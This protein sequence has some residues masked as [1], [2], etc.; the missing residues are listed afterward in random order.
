MKYLT[1]LLFVLVLFVGASAQSN[2]PLRVKEIDGDPSVNLVREIRVTNGTLTRVS[3]GVVQLTV[4]GGS[5]SPGGLDTQMQFNDGAAFGGDAGL[6]YNKTTNFLTVTGGGITLST[7]T[8]NK[9]TLTPPATGATLTVAD[10]KTLTVSNTLTFT[11]TDSAS[12]AFGAGGT[13]AYSNAANTFTVAQTVSLSG[14]TTGTDG[15]AITLT[16]NANALG[17]LAG[18]NSTVQGTGATNDDLYSALEFGSSYAGSGT[19]SI[20][21]GA[22]G[23][24]SITGTSVAAETSALVGS[25]AN[26]GSGTNTL[27]IG[28]KSD[29]TKASTG[30]ITTAVGVKS[31]ILNQNATGSIG[32]ARGLDLSGWSNSGTITTSAGI[33]ADTSIDVGTTKYFIKSLSVSPSELAGALLVSGV[34]TAGTSPTTLTDAA[35][36]ILSA[37]LNTVQ[38]AQGGTGVTA[39]GTGVATALGVNVGSAG[40]F[41]T[42]N[43]ALGTPSSGVVSTGVTLGDVTMNVTGTDATGDIYYRDA[44]GILTRLPVGST[45][46]V[47][48]VAAGLPSWGTDATGGG[49][50]PVVDTTSVVEGSADGTKEV[51]IEADGI[52]TGTVRVWTAPDSNTTIPIFSQIITFAG[53]TAARTVTF[54]DEAFTVAGVASTQTLSNKTLTAPRIADLGFI[55]DA[56]GNEAIIVDTVASAVNEITVANAATGTGPTISAT[57]GDTNIDLNLV[58]KGTGGVKITGTGTSYVGIGDTDNSHYL[59]LQV[60]TNL[61]ADRILTLTTGD[62]ART[63]TVNGNPTLDDWF[64]QSVKVAANPQFATVEV[65]AA[66]DTTLARSSAGNLSVEGN[67]IYRAGGTDVPVADG[68]TGASTLTGILQGN[69]TSAVTA[70]APGTGVVTA[71]GVNVG[72]AGAFVTFNGALGTPSSGVVS[73]GVTLGDVTMNVTG[74]DATG[75]IYY[76]DAGGLLARLGIGSTGQVIKVAAGLPSWGTDE[77]AGS[78]TWDTI[79]APAG[80]VSLVSN[81]TSETFTIDFQAAFTTGSQMVVKSST[82]NPTGGVLFEVLGHDADVQLLK[83]TNGGTNGIAVSAAGALTVTGSGTIVATTGDSATAFFSTGTLEAALLPAASESAQGAA[84][85]AT[86]AEINAGSDAARVIAVDQFNGSIFGQQDVQLEVLGDT[87]AATVADGHLY[88]VIP[89][90]LNGMNLVGVSAQVR[91]AG[92]TNTLNIDL[93]RCA[94][95]ATGNMCS[96]TVVDMLS[97]NL[98]ID[99]TENKSSTAATAAVIDT[100]NDDVA[101]DQVIRIDIDAIQ[102]TPSQ[103]LKVLLVFRLP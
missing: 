80:A 83:I 5:G 28:V 33:Y 47:L 66:S 101:T 52:T 34:L 48:K 38:P 12:V 96:G 51:R 65:G 69:G 63:I 2:P 10:G 49:A 82:G 8:I 44:S 4:T 50:L 46:Q 99:S 91:A 20:V 76:R 26:S 100:A 70:F 13:A 93:A 98:T 9:L 71:L 29:V 97:T 53:P 23:T 54:P 11:G 25:A 89:L 79:G 87:T 7:S 37:A 15:I 73:T 92:T 41:V 67:L 19:G 39:L 58:P 77:S 102:T 85:L 14:V 32:T 94:T 68:G 81:G 86:S 16:G 57:G 95:V 88:F 27:A 59:Q 55:A 42:F 3:S 18:V 21:Y 30:T 6:V 64:D 35:G 1:A 31:V 75:D 22:R 56:N 24:A 90:K 43:G 74:T 36:K 62:A 40:A 60:G 103:G 17:Q 78:P 72:S 84:E 61:T 45:D